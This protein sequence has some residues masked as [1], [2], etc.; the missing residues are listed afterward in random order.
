MENV[1]DMRTTIPRVLLALGQWRDRGWV[2]E[3]SYIS[4]FCPIF[5][6]EGRIMLKK[7]GPFSAPY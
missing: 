4:R 7:I 3:K 6:R 1:M 5:C 2:K